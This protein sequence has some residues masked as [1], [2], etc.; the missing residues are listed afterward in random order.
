MVGAATLPVI[1]RRQAPLA[2]AAAVSAG[3]VISG[4]P[5]FDQ[6]RCGAAIPAALFILFALANRTEWRAAV[7]GLALVLAGVIFLSFTDASIDPAALSFLLPLCAGVWVAGRVVRERDRLAA[8]L[9][10]R[11][12]ELEQRREQT[13]RLAVEVERARMAASLGTSRG[14]ACRRSST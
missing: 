7:G 10:R 6:T 2:C 4:I 12:V 1:W 13:A 9:T 5:T 11:T 3:M 8:E 14:R